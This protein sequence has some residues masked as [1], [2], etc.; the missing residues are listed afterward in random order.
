MLYVSVTPRLSSMILTR[1]KF[2]SR[3]VRIMS[4]RGY[5]YVAYRQ[6]GCVHSKIMNCTFL[7]I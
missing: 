7:S 6:R 5:R 2:S 3:I 4:A 1:E